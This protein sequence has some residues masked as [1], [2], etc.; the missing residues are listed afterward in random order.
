MQAV[1]DYKCALR[2][3]NYGAIYSLESF[4]RSGWFGDLSE[5]SELDPERVIDAIR[6][7]VGRPRKTSQ[8]K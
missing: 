5:L 8:K 1:D 6:A 3:R 7:Q 2:A 4:F